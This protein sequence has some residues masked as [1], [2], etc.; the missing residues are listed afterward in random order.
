MTILSRRACFFA[1]AGLVAVTAP[2][3]SA[4]EAE[5]QPSGE[6]VV[7]PRMIETPSLAAPVR[8]E[9]EL[10]GYVFVTIR[11]ALSDNVDVW[12]TRERNH[13]LRD[14]YVRVCFRQRLIDPARPTEVL[15]PLADNAFRAAAMEVLGARAVQSVTVAR[16]QALGSRVVRS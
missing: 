1:A 6:D 14:A 3:I 11:T 10:I 12:A 4:V 13:F 2:L 15:Q 8:R 9:N 5:A 16:T 7:G